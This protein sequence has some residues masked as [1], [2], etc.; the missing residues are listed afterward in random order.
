MFL[1]ALD[2]ACFHNKDNEHSSSQPSVRKSLACP[3]GRSAWALAPSLC[4]EALASC[5]KVVFLAQARVAGVEVGLL[6]RSNGGTSRCSFKKSCWG[7]VF[8]GVVGK[9]SLVLGS[10]VLVQDPRSEEARKSKRALNSATGNTAS[11]NTNGTKN[12]KPS[13]A[14]RRMVIIRCFGL[15]GQEEGGVENGPFLRV[16]PLSCFPFLLSIF[17]CFFFFFFLFIN[18]VSLWVLQVVKRVHTV[19]PQVGTACASKIPT[20]AGNSFAGK[21]PASPFSF[22]SFFVS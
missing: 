15:G 7:T 6:C 5:K 11:C 12:D 17:S 20:F 2:S 16:T 18:S 14:W 13:S 4:G 9:T 8:A 10:R 1:I 21:L 3:E 22:F 19:C